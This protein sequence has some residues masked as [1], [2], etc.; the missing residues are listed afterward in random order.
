M[1][2]RNKSR[3]VFVA[4]S[5]TATLLAT[6]IV[7][8]ASASFSDVKETHEF[9]T[10]INSAVALGIIKGYVDGTFGIN[11]NLKRSQVV[12]IIGRYLESLGYTSKAI[13]SSWSDVTDAEVIKYGNIVKE[14][15]VFTGY[16]DGTL[17]GGNF[18]TREN[19]A[20]VLDRLAKVVTGTSLSEVAKDIKDVKVADLATANV[21]YQSS[22]QALRDLGIST[23][24][25]FNPK[26]NLKRGQFAK[27]IVA[28]IEKMEAI[29]NAKVRTITS[30]SANNTDLSKVTV[31]FSNDVG[32]DA[33]DVNKYTVDGVKVFESAIFDGSNQKV[34]LTLKDGALTTSGTKTIKVSGV[35]NVTD[36]STTATFYENVRPVVVKLEIIAQDKIHLTF[37]EAIKNTTIDGTDIEVLVN[38]KK[39][40]QEIS[41][42]GQGTD[43]LVISLND[44]DKLASSN[45]QVK[46]N[47]KS[48]NDL[49]DTTG[50]LVPTTEIISFITNDTFTSLQANVAI[51]LETA[52]KKDLTNKDNLENAK[53]ALKSAQ[54][55]IKSDSALGKK[56]T[57]AA[58]LIIAMEEYNTKK[59][60][61]NIKVNNTS[62]A[63]V[64]EIQEAKTAIEAVAT[65][66]NE[67]TD[68]IAKT[69]LDLADLEAKVTSDS[70]ATIE[71]YKEIVAKNM[72]ANFDIIVKSEGGK[73]GLLTVVMPWVESLDR[74]NINTIILENPNNEKYYDKFA[75]IEKD[76]DLQA[77]SIGSY[78]ANEDFDVKVYIRAKDEL[79]TYFSGNNGKVVTI[80]VT[81]PK[82]NGK[83]AFGTPLKVS[84]SK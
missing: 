14:A 42:A 57:Q 47:I 36:Y 45:T 81:M 27:F 41:V 48:T 75:I 55:A 58:S 65:A 2:N 37:S 28:S 73:D 32:N 3:K 72:D 76:G 13:T 66:L 78:E 56:V 22:I 8:V 49:S 18:I 10:C 31:N 20:V 68:A 82:D 12:I 15:G 5:T 84:I 6:A 25:K 30:I 35:D 24:D 19:M 29:E 62:K 64:N 61:A 83:L 38:G 60:E 11:D 7:P 50:N 21:D 33:L 23:V 4:T 46:V 74:N 63:T 40:T 53:L 39:I 69:D 34:T 71:A 44:A 77:L 43:T 59:S 67:I 1:S 79:S 51:A 17:K 16:T 54:Q 52:L 70:T 80:N 26:S 9:T